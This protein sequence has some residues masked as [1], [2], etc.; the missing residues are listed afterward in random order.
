ME[1]IEILKEE[2][3]LKLLGNHKRILIIGCV[4]CTN[5]SCAYQNNIACFIKNGKDFIPYA[6]LEEIKRVKK[7]LVQNGKIV[8]Y[9]IEDSCELDDDKLLKHSINRTEINAIL[10][11]TCPAG[12]IGIMKTVGASVPIIEGVQNIGLI[13]PFTEKKEDGIYIN[14]KKST[15]IKA[16]FEHKKNIDLSLFWEEINSET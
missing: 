10:S 11:L 8:F 9:E 7:I 15:I 4:K 1:Y 12:T 14:K 2:E 3:I 6:V 5:Y 13:Q 16:C